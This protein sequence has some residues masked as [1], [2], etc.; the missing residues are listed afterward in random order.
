MHRP[1]D[2]CEYDALFARLGFGNLLS[3]RLRPLDRFAV[4]A[5]FMLPLFLLSKQ[6]E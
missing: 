2:M 6:Q 5:E 4:V 1:G 3:G